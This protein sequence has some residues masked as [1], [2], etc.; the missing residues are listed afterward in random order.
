MATVKSK[1][2]GNFVRLSAPGRTPLSAK[3][4]HATLDQI[5]KLHG[6]L[7]CGLIGIDININGPDPAPFAGGAEGI[8]VNVR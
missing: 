3:D 1:L 2:S 6:C 7:G 4:V 5:F 8:N